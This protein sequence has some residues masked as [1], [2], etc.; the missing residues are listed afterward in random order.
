MRKINKRYLQRDFMKVQDFGD[1]PITITE[2]L[3]AAKARK[4]A[5]KKNKSR[6][7]FPLIGRRKEQVEE[8][9]AFLNHKYLSTLEEIVQFCIDAG[10]P[11]SHSMISI[12]NRFG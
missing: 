4:K 12:P 3:T 9:W 1:A 8:L 7:T 2:V 11:F 5:E 6:A 10:M